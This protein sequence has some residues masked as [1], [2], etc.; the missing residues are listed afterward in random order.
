MTGGS[1]GRLTGVALAAV[2]LALADAE[3]QTAGP[4]LVVRGAA[5]TIEI[6]AEDRADI[7]ATVGPAGRLPAPE[8]RREGQTL[9]IDGKLQRRIRNCGSRGMPGGAP[10]VTV[11]GVGR[12]A[13]AELPTITIRAPRAL[14]AEIANAGRTR[15]GPTATA[16][17][18]FNGCGD[19]FLAPVAGDLSVRLDGSGDVDFA[20]V[21]GDLDA[22]LD[23][24]GDIRGGRTAGDAR[25][26][27]DGSGDVRVGAVDGA[28]NAGLDG[29]GDIVV[30]AVDG[31]A[32]LN[33]DGSGDILVRGGNAPRLAAGLDGSGD[34]AFL[35]AAGDVDAV[36][37]GSGDIRVSRAS[38]RVRKTKSGS[39]DISVGG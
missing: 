6:I 39:G 2:L 34:I 4:K 25:L 14:A 24:S 19:A 17:L 27:L 36:L 37:D 15:V 16:S 26:M 12:V 32:T 23:G 20:T 18:G 30:E 8:I 22:S 7:V 13:Y 9:L 35:G 5:A 10:G 29:S 33:L 1:T 31:P 21:G 3:A 38:G 11:N 28:L